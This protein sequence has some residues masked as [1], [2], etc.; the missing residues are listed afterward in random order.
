MKTMLGNFIPV[1]VASLLPGIPY[2]IEQVEAMFD[3]MRVCLARH[4]R[5]LWGSDATGEGVPPPLIPDRA[6]SRS[7]IPADLL[8]ERL[9]EHRRM[10]RVH[11]ENAGGRNGEPGLSRSWLS[12]ALRP[13]LAGVAIGATWGYAAWFLPVWLYVILT[14]TVSLADCVWAFRSLREM[15]ARERELRRTWAELERERDRRRHRYL[16]TSPREGSLG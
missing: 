9:E 12:R 4:L 13:I 7:D 8:R 3:E 5:R 16:E 15:R 2:T 1:G 10:N 14:S 6:V 11:E